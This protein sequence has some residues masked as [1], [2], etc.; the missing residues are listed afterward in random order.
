M[1]AR[2]SILILL[3]AMSCRAQVLLVMTPTNTTIKTLDMRQFSAA[4]KAI[5]TGKPEDAMGHED[6]MAWIEAG[7]PIPTTYPALADQ[8]LKIAVPWTGNLTN[9]VAELHRKDAE[10]RPAHTNY[11]GSL[12]GK[13]RKQFEADELV[14]IESAKG[15][16]QLREAVGAWL[17]MLSARMDAL[18]EANRVGINL[19]DEE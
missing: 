11:L 13:S 14:A 4:M 9:D 6:M 15:V 5:R 8:Q 1:V 19:K 12:K 2:M 16:P 3:A 7:Q 17:Q 18:E 10:R